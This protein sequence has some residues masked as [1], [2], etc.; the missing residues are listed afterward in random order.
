MDAGELDRALVEAERHRRMIEAV[1]IDVL[2]EAD[3]RRVFAADG[4]VSTRMGI[5]AHGGVVH[6]EPPPAPG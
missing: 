4:H 3:R 6:G 2:D 1:L 5:G